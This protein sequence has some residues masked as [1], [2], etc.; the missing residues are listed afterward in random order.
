M[1]PQETYDGLNAAY[2]MAVENGVLDVPSGMAV[3]AAHVQLRRDCDRT[4]SY[5]DVAKLSEETILGC[6]AWTNSDMTLHHCCGERK[7][8]LNIVRSRR[9][10]HELA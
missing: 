7:T 6:L 9:A 8:N 2:R 5:P 10:N 3:I 1:I 4:D